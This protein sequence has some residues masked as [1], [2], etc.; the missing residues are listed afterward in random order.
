MFGENIALSN[1]QLTL[2]SFEVIQLRDDGTK[3]KEKA[4][5]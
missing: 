1:V 2:Q 5:W 3:G 4:R